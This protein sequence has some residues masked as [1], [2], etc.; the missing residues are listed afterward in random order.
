MIELTDSQQHALDNKADEP[1]E[2]IDPRT[3]Q[4]YVLVRRE[5]YDRLRTLV[6][7]AGLDLRQV[8]I[9]VAN[10]MR[11]EDEGDPL[12]ESYQ[13]YRTSA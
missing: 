3:S 6:Q 8:A 4:K 7:D 13:K 1:L 10:A 5:M 9:L 11:E 2:V 12:L